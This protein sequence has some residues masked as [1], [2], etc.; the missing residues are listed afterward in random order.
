VRSDW[1]PIYVQAEQLL[2]SQPG[3][4]ILLSRSVIQVDGH[5]MYEFPLAS[6]VSLYV[7]GFV[8][9][10]HYTDSQQ[11]DMAHGRQAGWIQDEVSI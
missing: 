9:S 10:V 4:A 5:I 8:L 1:L 6:R 7:I 2:P 11:R 3:G